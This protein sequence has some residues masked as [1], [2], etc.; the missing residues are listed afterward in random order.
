MNLSHQEK[1]DRKTDKPERRPK[2]HAVDDASAISIGGRFAHRRCRFESEGQV[3][4]Q[5]EGRWPYVK[6]TTRPKRVKDVKV[7][8]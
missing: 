1:G 3:M 6:R 2:Q 8:V 4:T 5:Y 7:L